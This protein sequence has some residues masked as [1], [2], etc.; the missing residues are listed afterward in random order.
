MARE[1]PLA[2][3]LDDIQWADEGSLELL[4]FL[5]RETRGTSVLFLICY[6]DADI[7]RE[8]ALAKVVR[9]MA[10]EG[11]AERI[12]LGRLSPDETAALVENAFGGVDVPAEFTEF[13]Y[14][15]TKGNPF[16]IKKMVEALGGHYR[17]VRQIAAGGMGRVFEAVDTVTGQRVAAKLM[18]A[19]AEADPKAFLRFQQEAHV[20]AAL[21]HSNI[22]RVFGAFAEEHASCIIMELVE[23]RSMADVLEAESLSLSRIKHMV[24]QVVAA[25]AGAHE[26]GIVHRDIKPD[27]I[28]LGDGDLVKVTDFGI[29]RLMR[30]VGETTLTA[31][32]MAMGTPLYMSPEQ[33]RAEEIDNRTDIYSLGA[34][35]YRLATGRPPFEGNDPISIAYQHV[36][37]QP[38]PPRV[39]RPELPE[40]WESVILRALAK[41]PNERF[42]TAVAMERV[43]EAL[44]EEADTRN[45]A[46][47]VLAASDH[48]PRAANIT[49][50]PAKT[51][52]RRRWAWL[53]APA[54]I[55]L[56]TALILSVRSLGL[57]ASAGGTDLLSG[58]T[59]IAV[60]GRGSLYVVD[61]DNNRVREFSP[62]GKSIGSWGSFGN[63]I[64]QFHSPSDIAI[65]PP[66][67]LYV[68]DAG[69]KRI[70]V[71][72][73]GREV[74][75]IQ[76]DV[77]SLAVDRQGNVYSTDYGHAQ[78]RKFYG[79]GPAYTSIAIPEIDVSSFSFPAGIAIGSQGQIYIANRFDNGVAALSPSGTPVQFFGRKDHQPG[80]APGE[81][82]TPSDVTLDRQGNVYVADTYN[83]RIQK[84][85][86][87]GKPLA[88]LASTKGRHFDLPT[89]IAVD[90]HGNV[91]LSEH[92][93]NL[94]MKL[95]ATGRLIW[96]TD[97][98]HLHQNG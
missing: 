86:P 16:F 90:A 70:L 24:L 49:P 83:N 36:H 71:I 79:E 8:H 84:F 10:R 12:T 46:A 69:S 15:R 58:P 77:G 42:Q 78:I 87:R 6:R 13:V 53:A 76:F 11:L 56:L 80:S 64:L 81:F 75:D 27:N 98:Q 88:V 68:S 19:R 89:S 25:L 60:D 97:G 34:V 26:R 74:K 61:A 39:L 29:A 40:A 7:S 96:S 59:G 35:L 33:I 85:S 54:I 30:P 41:D 82:N 4:H 73:R 48:Y 44:P 57:G 51:I 37:E 20:L 50:R 17:L 21:D 92:Y 52:A 31:T 91:Y 45:Q 28:M 72:Q 5:A 63:G 66:E 65:R 94:V 14:R 9:N 43:L 62:D 95:S 47:L 55:L 22:V 23:G 67:R 93:D 32:G 2:L 18:F 38:I 1:R 3:M